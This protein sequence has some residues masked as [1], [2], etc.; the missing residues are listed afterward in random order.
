MAGTEG[1]G[2]AGPAPEAR[3][4]GLWDLRATDTVPAA[5]SYPPGA[6][7]VASGLPGSGKS[8][9]LHRWS[10]AAAAAAAVIDPRTVHVACEAV[11]P[12]WLPYAV[13]RPW[14]RARLLL[15]LRAGLGRDRP[16]LVHDCGSRPWLRRLL[17]R[18]A[19][20]RGR[21]LHL[22][23]LDVGPAVALSGQRARDRWVRRR[24]FAR[25]CR[26][27]GRLLGTLPRPGAPAAAALPAALAG[28]ASVVLLDEA[29]RAKVRAVR[30][31]AAAGQLP[32]PG[33]GAAAASSVLPPEP[34]RDA[35]PPSPDSVRIAGPPRP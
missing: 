16:L 12:D 28:V 11:M 13:Y 1:A 7:V 32:E 27:L 5:L 2:A 30:F 31:T 34:S 15:W 6:V 22:V 8:T 26:G 19:A 17:A 10:A 24:V 3:P 14:A 9:V 21:S 33:V 25:H 29:S 20:R 18:S 23:V 4:Q 35:V